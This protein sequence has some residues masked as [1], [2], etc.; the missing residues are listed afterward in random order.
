M[1]KLTDSITLRHGAV[2]NNR[3]VQTP[4]LTNSGQDE[5]VT[6]DTVNYYASRS[7]SA[8]MVIAEYTSVSPN[9]GPSRSWAKD[10]EQL[11]IYDDKFIPGLTKVAQVLKKDGNKALL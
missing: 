1:K 6:D 5:T 7:Q 11:A 10:R 4:M 3:I 8:G 9:G 2:L